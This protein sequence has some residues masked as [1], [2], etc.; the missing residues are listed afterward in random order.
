[1]TLKGDGSYCA[2]G[3]SRTAF[4]LFAT[5]KSLNS[6]DGITIISF[7]ELMVVVT[8]QKI[9]FFSILIAITKFIALV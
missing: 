4:V 2:C 5:R 7:G 1:M 9:V 6:R 3:K 8:K